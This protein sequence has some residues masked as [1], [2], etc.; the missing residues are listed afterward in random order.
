MLG[1]QQVLS[2]DAELRMLAPAP[3]HTHIEP[4]IGRHLLKRQLSHVVAGNIEFQPVAQ[5]NGGTNVELL[6]RSFR[7][8]IASS[9]VMGAL[10]G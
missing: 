8:E 1:I 7:L 10:A 4:G 5:I 9:T 2:S 6:S 3:A